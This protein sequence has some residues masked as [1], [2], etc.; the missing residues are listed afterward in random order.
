MTDLMPV[1]IKVNIDASG[2]ASGVTVVSN[3]L[4]R[5]KMKAHESA[6]SFGKI[7]ETMLGVFGG[8]LLT[9]GMMGIERVL[10]EFKNESINA[11]VAIASLGNAMD[12]LKGSTETSRED[13]LK[14]AESYS[15]LG[16]KVSDSVTA[17]STLVTATGDVHQAQML[18]SLSADFA[19]KRHISM[20]EA[21]SVM[22]RATTG[23]LKAFK[24]LG[25]TLDST[26]PKNQAITKAFD[27]L[28]RRIGG[29]AQA[30]TKTFAGQMDILK[31]K[32][33]TFAD[34]ISSKVLPPIATLL[35]YI[36]RNAGAI[37]V[38]AGAVLATI[39]VLKTYISVMTVLKKVQ[40]AYAFWTYT[41]TV[42]TN[43]FR[44]SVQALWTTMK[45]NPIGAVVT[46]IAI[47]GAAFVWAWNKFDWWRGGI[48]KGIQIIINAFGY[49]IGY[50]AT[51]FKYLGKIPGFGWAKT[52]SEELGKAA[53]SVRKYG[54]SLDKLKN[55]KIGGGGGDKF[56]TPNTSGIKGNVING[57]ATKNGGGGAGGGSGTTMYMTV[58]A[59]DTNDIARKLAKATKVGLPIGG[60]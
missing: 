59:S 4:N 58:Y 39:T 47:L 33:Q 3:E 46:A 7:K 10:E 26:L 45:A 5:L 29:S 19:R 52:A 53:D 41:Q 20:A 6:F 12:N 55:K 15:K 42:S 14:T 44:F 25:I 22:A 21:S 2:V 48:V 35:G 49:L 17:M 34:V 28:N 11:Q 32:F 40:Q 56:V 23:N 31:E 16:F 57:D 36:T 38:W 50:Y 24:A 9:S 8:N 51:L 27:E 43:F 13:A 30:Y 54:D 18:M 37:L 1:N 60:R